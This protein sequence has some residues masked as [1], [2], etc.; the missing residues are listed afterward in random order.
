M[1]TQTF[2]LNLIPD[3]APIVVN[4]DQYDKGTGRLIIELYEDDIAY[5]P[6]GSAI[7]QG[8]KPDGHGF[9]YAATLVGN[10][11]T[12]DLTEQMTAVAG[13]VRCQVVVTET[14]GRTGTFVFMLDVQRSAL[15]DNTEMSDYDYQIVEQ[16]I[17]NAEGWAV[18][19]HGG[20]PVDPDDPTYNNNAKYWA[21]IASQ[22]AQGGII[23]KGSVLFANIPVSGMSD[24]D[25]YNIQDDFTT[26]S[27]FE[28]GPGIECKAGTNI[29]WKRYLYTGLCLMG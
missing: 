12:A 29:V 10:V 20:V 13:R 27:R 16:A 22:Y 28:E 11:V 15:P 9:A 14:S 3:S 23:Y 17:L 6:T 25:M 7:I 21:E 5:T 26:D 2:K 24:G 1:I 18:G 4:C 8:T 19:E